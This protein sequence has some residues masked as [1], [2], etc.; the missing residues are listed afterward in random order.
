MLYEVIT[1]NK[2]GATGCGYIVARMLGNL[3]RPLER[4]IREGIDNDDLYAIEAA[5][6]I[7]D[8]EPETE[9]SLVN[10]VIRRPYSEAVYSLVRS[11]S[12]KKPE[13]V[14][15]ITSYNVCYTKLLRTS[16]R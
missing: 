15:R 9:L 13:I 5:G 2:I 12:H 1:Y 14:N 7:G 10:A 3:S 4:Y 16:A 11:G 8:I 6:F